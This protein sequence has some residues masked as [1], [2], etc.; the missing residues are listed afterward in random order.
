GIPAFGA[1][2]L[3]FTFLS[4]ASPGRDIKFDLNRCEGYRNFCNKLWNA[5]R[6][7]LMNTA[8]QDNGIDLAAPERCPDGLRFSFADRW[9]VGRLQRAEAEA[10]RHFAD[11]RFDLLA[12]AIYEFVWDE[13]CDW[14]LELAKVQLQTGAP[15]ESRAT[16]RTLL[17]TLEAVL[18]LAHPLIPFITEELWQAV[19][20]LAGRKTH[21]S[22]MLAAYP[23]ADPAKFDEASEGQVRQLKEIVYACRNLRGEMDISPARRMPLFA[24]GDA[25]ALKRC[26]PYL[27]A[28]AKLSEVHVVDRLPEDAN[29]PVAIVGEIRLML[30]VEIDVAAE[31]ERIGK[32]IARLE[33]E[34]DRAGAKLAN[35]SFVA[36]A[37]AP[38]VEQERKRLA[39]FTAAL[40][41]LRRLL[42]RL[43]PR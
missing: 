6:F 18:R 17:H 33:G 2:A 1:D 23:E 39:D 30:E 35:E 13:F 43:A 24:S 15:E 5:A 38:V 32:E 25:E 36:R 3:R 19:A 12:R 4:L 29:A 9:I 31:T 20:P 27:K 34:I 10:A 8:N 16:R 41:K 37:P 28:L 11:Y 42:E 26:A 7:V 21:D 40:E 22:I 14:Y